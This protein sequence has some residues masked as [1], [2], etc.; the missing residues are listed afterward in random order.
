MRRRV[1]LNMDK[2]LKIL[3]L[4]IE[5]KRS[6]LNNLAIEA[7]KYSREQIIELSQELDK[8]IFDYMKKTGEKTE[9][10]LRRAP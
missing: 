9:K 10:K 3:L 6:K 4:K 2:E 1:P 8:L 5:I 7:N